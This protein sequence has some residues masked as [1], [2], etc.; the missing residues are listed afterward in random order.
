MNVDD[1]S[2]QDEEDG[3]G[4]KTVTLP[5]GASGGTF[6]LSI[7]GQKSADIA[8]NSNGTAVQLILRQVKGGE[9]ASVTGRA[10]GPFTVKGVTGVLTADGTNLTG[11]SSQEVTVA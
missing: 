10:G 7:D 3:A 11:S 9:K 6:T 5:S 1:D 4:E 2:G 8:Q